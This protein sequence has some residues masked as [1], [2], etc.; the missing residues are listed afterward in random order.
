MEIGKRMYAFTFT[1][2]K[3][4]RPNPN[5]DGILRTHR[6]YI[7]YYSLLGDQNPV[8]AVKTGKPNITFPVKFVELLIDFAKDLNGEV[9]H[10]KNVKIPRTELQ[11]RKFFVGLPSELAFRRHLLFALTISTYRRESAVRFNALKNLLLVMNANSLNILSA[12]ALD[13]YSELKTSHSP[14]WL[15]HVLRVGRALKV[16]YMLD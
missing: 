5:Y 16:L 9:I 15:W 11:Y 2:K 7:E 6:F 12:I 1:V 13:R 10:V 14:T 4:S 3:R 8:D